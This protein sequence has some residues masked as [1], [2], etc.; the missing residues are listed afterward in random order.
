MTEIVAGSRTVPITT[1]VNGEPWS[2]KVPG[3]ETLLEFV[4][5][6]LHL[7]GTK[8]SCE[9]EVCG[10]CSVLVDGAVVSSCNMLAFEVHG[11]SVT[12]VE[13]LAVGGELSPLQEAFVSEGAIQCGYCTPGQVMS[14]SALLTENPRCSVDDIREWMAGNICR[15]GCYTAIVRAIR[16][17]ASSEG[18][19][20]EL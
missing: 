10:A 11:R 14:A 15:C 9:S 5:A 3:G 4:R 8:R 18:E 6:R 17:I 12:T 7:M 20:D 19:Q 16:S 13:G 2:G 1:E